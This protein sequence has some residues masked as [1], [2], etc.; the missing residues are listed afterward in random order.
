MSRR[1]I[2]R[3]A[4]AH[5]F[6][7]IGDSALSPDGALHN[8]GIRIGDEFAD[9]EYFADGALVVENGLIAQIGD[10]STILANVGDARVV[11][12][13]QSLIVPGFVDAH[14]HFPQVDIIA[15]Y[16]LSLL[17]WLE[18]YTFPAEM[19]YQDPAHCE[20]M[21]EFF[22]NCLLRYG[23]TTALVFASAH[24]HS[25]DALFA[26]AHHRRMRLFTGKV[27]MDRH[28]PPALCDTP[29]SSFDDSLALAKKWHRAGRLGYAVTPRFAIT[30]SEQQLTAARRLLD[31]IPDAL[32]H[33][34]L[35]ENHSEIAWVKELFP[36]A[37][38][39][40]G[41]YDKF[42][43]VEQRCVFAHCLHLC[44][45]EW[46]RMQSANA[47]IACCPTS[48]LFLG[49]GLF[50]FS[51]AR[52]YGLRVGYGSDV[53]GGTSFS[54]FRVMDESYKVARLN[55]EKLSPLALW[56]TATLGGANALNVAD[57]IGNFGNGKEAD[58]IVLDLS[59]T[60]LL[61]RRIQQC[62]T[63]IEMLF[64][65]AI[66]GDENTVKATYIYGKS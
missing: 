41:V 26:A 59:A 37:P 53:G 54:P 57:K 52:H 11:E 4:I 47:A 9:C 43:L 34:H 62:E 19:R 36:D 23:I 48:N 21:A 14:V 44:D 24:P 16:G 61:T 31:E 27:M 18:K 56:H 22:I 13:P 50:R 12:Y 3:S 45:D 17:E 2:Y 25:A 1:V 10:A 28:A 49:S 30:S 15:S 65:L 63:I 46:R 42:G 29:Q 6:D 40:L 55:S 38:N 8:N 66:L 5:F 33:T 35:S 39:Y 58:F 20:I 7:A 51:V 32:L 64:A 60:P